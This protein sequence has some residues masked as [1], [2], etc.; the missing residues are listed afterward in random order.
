MSQFTQSVVSLRSPDEPLDL[1]PHC[2]LTVP[3]RN[4]Q[5]LADAIIKLYE[6]PEEEREAMGRRGRKYVE[7]HH[8]IPMLA[9]K[10]ETCIRE[11]LHGA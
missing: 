7:E 5:A 2:G 9:D 6:M 3:P 1:L 11:V 10:L 4:P 8:A